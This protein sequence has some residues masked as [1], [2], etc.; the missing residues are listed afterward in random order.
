MQEHFLVLSILLA[1]AIIVAA[2]V[3]AR[4]FES[5]KNFRNRN[6]DPTEIDT[7]HTAGVFTLPNS[8]PHLSNA[9]VNTLSLPEATMPSEQL[10]N[11]EPSISPSVIAPPSDVT[12]PTLI[13]DEIE[14]K[15]KKTHTLNGNLERKAQDSVTEMI[16]ISPSETGFDVLMQRD[17][18]ETAKETSE[19]KA[20]QENGGGLSS[21]LRK[22][23]LTADR[24]YS[25]K[26]RTKEKG[27]FRGAP[28]GQRDKIPREL[29]KTKEISSKLK[30][31]LV[32]WRRV[33]KWLIGIE[34]PKDYFSDDIQEVFQNSKKMLRNESKDQCWCLE[35]LTDPLEVK[36]GNEN[37][38]NIDYVPINSVFG[39]RS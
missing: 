22:P 31:E 32:C 1:A 8:Q 34:I 38:P 10:G 28:K 7:Y 20:H 6:I 23:I 35:S 33:G 12:I 16:A 21:E 2:L 36:W 25:L 39:V 14:R 26:H 4:L 29:S 30:P 37:N 13:G 5:K 17:V 18:V 11:E 15:E 9:A 3:A 27:N 19:D 24:N